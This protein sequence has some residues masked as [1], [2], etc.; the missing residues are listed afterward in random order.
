MFCH[1]HPPQMPKCSQKGRTLS[2]EG[3]VIL[4]SLPSMKDFFFL[5]IIISPMSP[6]MASW[7]KTTCS[8]IRATARPSEEVP[9]IFMF[10][11]VFLIIGGAKVGIIKGFKNKLFLI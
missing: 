7:T 3:V 6:G 5:Y 9:V 11:I 10:S 2:I 8:F 1:L 4:I